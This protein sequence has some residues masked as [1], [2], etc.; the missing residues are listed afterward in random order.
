MDH[1]QYHDIILLFQFSI[2]LNLIYLYLTNFI[3]CYIITTCLNM[4]HLTNV[5]ISY[6]LPKET[7]NNKNPVILYFLTFKIQM[8]Q[9]F[10]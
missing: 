6:D 1:D 3:I 4:I 9:L 8:Y 7:H 2:Y 10:K 5:Q